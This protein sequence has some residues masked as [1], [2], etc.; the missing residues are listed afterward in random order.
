DLAAAARSRAGRRGRHL[1]P[2][3]G[4]SHRHQTRGPTAEGPRRHPPARTVERGRRMTARLPAP[5]AAQR[6]AIRA[7]SERV[8]S[9]EEAAAYRAAP[10]LPEEGAEAFALTAWSRRRYP[11]PPEPLAYA[12]RAYRRWTGRRP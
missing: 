2:V 6:E 3:A 1:H 10:V 11:P 5:T 8:L 7:A 12:R 4:R 9:V